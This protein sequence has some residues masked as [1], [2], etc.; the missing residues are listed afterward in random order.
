MVNLFLQSV[1]AVPTVKVVFIKVSMVTGVENVPNKVHKATVKEVPNMF[2]QTL[3]DTQRMNFCLIPKPNTPLDETG[4]RC[5]FYKLY[6][7]ITYY[8]TLLRTHTK[9]INAAPVMITAVG[10]TDHVGLS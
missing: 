3:T 5:A 2:A 9:R 6:G 7:Q 1:S 4:V 8:L 10:F